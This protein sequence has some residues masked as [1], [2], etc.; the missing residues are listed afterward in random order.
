MLNVCGSIIQDYLNAGGSTS[1]HN[2]STALQHALLWFYE[3][4]KQESDLIAVVNFSACLDALANGQDKSGICRLISA[5][6]GVTQD[7]RIFVGGPRVADLVEDIYSYG[8]SR[9]IHGSNLRLREDWK[10]SR[11]RS[12]RLA[13]YCLISCLRWGSTNSL[14]SHPRELQAIAA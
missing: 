13:R 4:C 12:E 3:G 7:H 9:T 5:R 8:R 6:L 11:A 10:L 2:V 1:R 14:E